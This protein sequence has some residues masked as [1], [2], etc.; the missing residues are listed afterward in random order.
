MVKLFVSY[1]YI[2]LRKTGEYRGFGNTEVRCDSMPESIE[3]VNFI[4]RGILNDIERSGVTDR[5][6]NIRVLYWKAL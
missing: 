2:E 3:D 6:V 4:E 5:V 1:T